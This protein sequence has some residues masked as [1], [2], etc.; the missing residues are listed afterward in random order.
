MSETSAVKRARPLSPHLQIYRLPVVAV[1]SITHRI[2]GI[3]LTVGTLLLTWWLVAAAA[4]PEAYDTV[5]AVIGSPIGLLALLGWTWAFSYHLLKGIQHL[6]W[7]T[8]RGF[9][10]AG[11]A[12]SSQVVFAGSFILTVVIWIAAYAQ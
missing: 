2:T 1:S 7:D 10:K 3:A 6:I 9:D 8:V 4:G 12:K 5:R 11:A